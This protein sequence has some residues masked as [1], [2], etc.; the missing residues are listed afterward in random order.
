[1]NGVLDALMHS[2]LLYVRELGDDLYSAIFYISIRL[3][4]NTNP[5][6][7]KKIYFLLK[8][9]CYDEVTSFFT[10]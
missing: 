2:Y 6:V 8:T 5:H 10:I 9:K 3:Y 7:K 1:M 4:K